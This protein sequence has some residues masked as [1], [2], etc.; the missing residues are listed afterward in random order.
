MAGVRRV[1]HAD[2]GIH[3]GLALGDQRLTDLT[4][5]AEHD[6]G[7]ATPHGGASDRTGAAGSAGTTAGVTERTQMGAKPWWQL[8]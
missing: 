6:D 2:A 4:C 5:L 8:R 7:R 3:C 1:Q